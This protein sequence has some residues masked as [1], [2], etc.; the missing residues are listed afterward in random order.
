MAST[1]ENALR[2]VK[3][4]EMVVS[5]TA[6]FD[7]LGNKLTDDEKQQLLLA[8]LS[9]RREKVQP[10]DL[11]TT[12]LMN[13]LLVDVADLHVRVLK[14]ESQ[15]DQLAGKVRIDRVIPSGT[16][17]TVGDTVTIEGGNFEYSLG[18]AAVFFGGKKATQFQ[19]GSN[20]QVLLVTVTDPGSLSENGTEIDLVVSNRSSSDSTKVKVKPKPIPLTGSVGLTPGT[21]TP[22][23]LKA[24]TAARFNYTLISAAS[25]EATFNLVIKLAADGQ[26]FDPPQYNGL[27]SILDKSNSPLP[28]N[29]IRLIPG[30]PETIS[31]N[32]SSLPFPDQ[33]KFNIQVVANADG[34]SGSSPLKTYVVGT[35]SNDDDFIALS[36]NGLDDP[37]KLVGGEIRLGANDSVFATLTVT[38][39]QKAIQA[40][41]TSAD[42][43]VARA[44]SQGTDWN[45]F[46]S[47]QSGKVTVGAPAGFDIEITT[48]AN[49]SVTGRIDV[50]V[51]RR[52]QGGTAVKSK[53]YGL[54]LR[55]S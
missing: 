35:E 13:Q 15:G 8:M 54:L 42:Y 22:D 33:S 2:L 18:A 25:R 44:V 36:L 27:V 55:R 50:I 6:I 48:G 12:A 4:G 34:A 38:L 23:P 16:V 7:K 49:P 51:T 41:V 53:Q 37:T 52:S 20:D 43:D 26:P 14:L 21:V 46:L 47:S 9:P 17:L 1:L 3:P 45:G 5:L 40:G 11:I 10:G 30:T 32:V 29:S 19:P 24:F 39:T 31:V 28:N